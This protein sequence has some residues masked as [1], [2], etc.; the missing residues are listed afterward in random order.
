MDWGC[1]DLT[2]LIGV[3]RPVRVDVTA[4]WSVNPE[5]EVHLAPGVIFNTDQQIGASLVFH[6]AGG[7]RVP[8]IYE[9]AAA[10]HGA[11]RQIVEIEGRRG[12]VR[13][14]WLD[15]AGD[16]RVTVTTD[17]DGRAAETT[18]YPGHPIT[19]AHQR[20]LLALAARLRGEPNDSVVGDQALFTFRC[21]RA[22]QDAATTGQPQTI[23]LEELAG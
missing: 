11:A 16:G 23:T 9:R 15:W 22:I 6:R 4:A 5:T 10:T 7:E 3:L 14:D 13:W 20:P 2:T 12:A 8:I 19:P 1:Y 18:H 21:L 17:R